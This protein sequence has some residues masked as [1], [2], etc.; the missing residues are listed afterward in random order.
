MNTIPLL[1]TNIHP[2]SYK[3][4]IEEVGNWTK[5]N[6]SKMICI[7][8]VHMIMEAVDDPKF[9]S[10]INGADILTP[11]G[12]PLVW[13]LRKNGFNDQQRVYGPTLMTHLFDYANQAG[14]S[15]GFFG[16]TPKTIEEIKRKINLIFPSINLNYLFSPPFRKMSVKENESIAND[17]ND[18]KI[19]ILFVGLGCPKQEIW[20]ASQL[21]KIN[22]TMIGVGAAFDFYAGNISQAPNWMQKIGM[23]WFYRL[24]KEP[25]RLW[26]RYLI[27]NARFLYLLISGWLTG[28]NYV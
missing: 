21:G 28:K 16:S 2:T 5:E 18:A 25:R 11:D 24:L 7:G 23:E 17:I 15:I 3:L 27:L 13:Y 8:N 4:I 14:I 9:R 1:G 19:D 6:L 10:M 12:M 20:M 26:R 22:A